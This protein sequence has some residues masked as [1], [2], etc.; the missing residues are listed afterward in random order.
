LSSIHRWLQSDI[1]EPGINETL[2]QQLQAKITG[3]SKRDCHCVLAMDEMSVKRGLR[4]CKLRDRVVGFE[5][6]GSRRTAT[7]ATSAFVFLVK[8]LF[9]HWKQ[10]VYFAFTSHKMKSHT[11]RD[12]VETV[13]TK[14][15][16]IGLTVKVLVSDQGSVFCKMLNDNSVTIAHPYLTISGKNIL[17]L[18]D[19]PHLLKNIRNMLYHHDVSHYYGIARWSHIDQFYNVD[20]QQ[21]FRLAPRL[22]DK[23]INLPAFS[24]M[25]VKLATQVLS[26][27]VA[28]GIETHIALASLPAEATGTADFC[29]R[30]DKLFDCFNSS[31]PFAVNKFIRAIKADTEH[32]DHLSDA[33][34]WLKS[35]KVLRKDGRDV[36]ATYKCIKGWLQAIAVLKLL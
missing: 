24:K 31:A 30:F 11:V 14:L 6:D 27:S 32:F 8:G 12:I 1:V 16:S 25:K 9:A 20:S 2:Y 35:L 7:P 21:K 5:D 13:V 23:H 15:F 29:D 18:P 19:P 17:V 33:A 28:A 4:Y 10:A 22:T 34:K 36:T 3:M 26:H